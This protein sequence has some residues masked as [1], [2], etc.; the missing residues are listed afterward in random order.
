MENFK[1]HPLN[2]GKD[3]INMYT[4][5]ATE[6][7]RLLTNLAH[8]PFDIPD[9]HFESVEGYW[10]WLLTDK[11]FDRLKKLHGFE[12]KK[13]G[14]DLKKAGYMTKSSS[15]EDF[16]ENIKKAIREKLK[17]NPHILV[18]LLKTTLPL[19]HYYYYQGT[20]NKESYSIQEKTQYYWINEEIERLRNI[21]FK[22]MATAGQLS[23]EK[24]SEEEV[25]LIKRPR[26]K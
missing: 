13:A 12:A 9:G 22:K 3:H 8:T 21:C 15:D 24:P 2:D 18:M 4:K 16:K 11:Q 23:S 17:Q 7:G 20:K 19:K 5:G 1:I 26:F 10:F 14:Q 6:L 25:N